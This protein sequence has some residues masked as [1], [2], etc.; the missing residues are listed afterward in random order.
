MVFSQMLADVSK[1]QTPLV[2]SGKKEAQIAVKNSLM[3]KVFVHES[4][5]KF[6]EFVK[7]DGSIEVPTLN[8]RP[9]FLDP[10]LNPMHH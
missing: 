6:I 3:K 1:G 8:P 5:N 4:M 2:V 7:K 9:K 10:N